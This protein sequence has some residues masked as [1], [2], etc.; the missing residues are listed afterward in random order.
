MKDSAF[1]RR[2]SYNPRESIGRPLAYNP[3][4]G[5]LKQVENKKKL[6]AD[7]T[8]LNESVSVK[9]ASINGATE[10]RKSIFGLQRNMEKEKL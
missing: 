1:Q 9:T 5:K 8:N 4:H 10:K 3:H 7:A 6:A 2:K